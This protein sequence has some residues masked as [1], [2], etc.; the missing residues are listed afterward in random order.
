MKMF[1]ETLNN[2]DGATAIEYALIAAIIAMALVTA[3]TN[4]GGTLKGT[5]TKIDS[6]IKSA[7]SSV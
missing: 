4:I 3:L 6:R 2:E 1:L 7:N 5:F